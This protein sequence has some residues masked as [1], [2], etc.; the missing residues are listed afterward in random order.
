[1]PSNF[2]LKTKLEPQNPRKA[3]R[4]Q[5]GHPGYGDEMA[6]AGYATLDHASSGDGYGNKERRGLAPDA[7]YAK[8]YC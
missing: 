3:E 8:R 7:N 2:D 5:T 6:A 4:L 1:M